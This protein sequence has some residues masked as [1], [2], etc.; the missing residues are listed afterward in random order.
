MKKQCKEY[1]FL[2]TSY[3]DGESEEADK[4]EVFLHLA[5]CDSCRTYW[6]TVTEMKFQAA[7]ENRRAAPT[8]LNRRI[9]VGTMRRVSS[10]RLS[11]AGGNLIQRRI[12]VPAPV[13]LLLALFL[14]S[15]GAGIAFLWSS[16]P[17]PAKE[18]VEPVVVVKLPTVEIRGNVDQPESSVR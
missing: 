17:P 15:G 9:K 1:E 10:A 14:L 4:R 6:E 7:R 2:I 16:S 18:V 12:F 11:R 13:A 5:E 3:A 8:T